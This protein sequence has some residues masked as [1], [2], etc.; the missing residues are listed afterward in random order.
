MLFFREP[1]TIHPAILA[2][3]LV[4]F[5][6]GFSRWLKALAPSLSSK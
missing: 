3:Y 6:R 4:G 2:R 1:L 5:D